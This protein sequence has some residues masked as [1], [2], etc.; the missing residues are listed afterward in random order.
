MELVKLEERIELTIFPCLFAMM[1]K[2]RD[3]TASLGVSKIGY[4]VLG[5]QSTLKL[6]QALGRCDLIFSDLSFEDAASQE[7]Y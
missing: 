3:E 5:L 2:M 7:I 6:L 1:N 4:E